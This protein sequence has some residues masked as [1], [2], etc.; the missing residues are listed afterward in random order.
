TPFVFPFGIS[1]AVIAVKAFAIRIRLRRLLTLAMVI[2][3][4][5][6]PLYVLIVPVFKLSGEISEKIAPSSKT[7]IFANQVRCNITNGKIHIAGEFVLSGVDRGVI[8][9]RGILVYS[10]SR[11][12]MGRTTDADPDT[13]LTKGNYVHF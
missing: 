9:G 1:L 12:F 11:L 3:F 8:R 4:V 13:F 6:I 7:I 2:V 5:P 10:G